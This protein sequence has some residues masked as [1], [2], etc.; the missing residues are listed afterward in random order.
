LVPQEN[1]KVAKN[2]ATFLIKLTD[3][4]IDE[5]LRKS[6]RIASVATRPSSS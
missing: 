5:I 4:H 3:T 2:L 6:I 1:I